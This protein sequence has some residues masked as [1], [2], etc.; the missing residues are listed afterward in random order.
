MAQ[1]KIY[2]VNG[3]DHWYVV[4]QQP[5]GAVEKYPDE[6]KPAAKAKTTANKART[7]ASK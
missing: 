3:S 5:E 7:S 4:G 2:T 1:M 6:K